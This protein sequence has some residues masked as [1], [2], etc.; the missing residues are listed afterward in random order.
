MDARRG[1]DGSIG[2]IVQGISHGCDFLCNFVG[3]RQDPEG[4]VS[5]EVFE[6]LIEATFSTLTA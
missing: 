2:G 4:W 3:E 6:K 1:D 5:L